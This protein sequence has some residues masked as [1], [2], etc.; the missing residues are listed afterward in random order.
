ML[1]TVR[2][3]DVPLPPPVVV[4]VSELDPDSI[5]VCV[6]A[7]LFPL[8]VSVE[9]LL[10]VSVPLY[11]PRPSVPDTGIEAD[12]Q[13]EGSFGLGQPAKMS[14]CHPEVAVSIGVLGIESD[15]FAELGQCIGGF[16]LPD[17]TAPGLLMTL[18]LRMR[19]VRWRWGWQS[20]CSG[21]STA[22]ELGMKVIAADFTC[23]G[24]KD[25]EQGYII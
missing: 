11:V 7:M 1:V 15:G 9:V 18:R 13:S 5:A 24:R 10:L 20:G 4:T 8:S 16:A 19:C 3:Y 22:G 25:S 17:Q 2:L 23:E 21:L 14:E 12:R 6:P